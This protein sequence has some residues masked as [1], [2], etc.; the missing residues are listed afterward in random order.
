MIAMFGRACEGGPLTNLAPG[1]E[2]DLGRHPESKEKHAAT[3][4]YDPS[5]P[6]TDQD[7]HKLNELMASVLKVKSNPLKPRSKFKGRGVKHTTGTTRSTT[8]K[9]RSAAALAIAAS[10]NGVR[11]IEGETLP[12]CF[13]YRGIPAILENGVSNDI[14]GTGIAVVHPSVDPADERFQITSRG[15]R[16]IIVLLGRECLETLSLL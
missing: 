1:R 11:L 5:N 7:T 4:A 3:L 13:V 6:A 14:I 2:S 8:P 12:R 10:L 15:E 16:V 9:Q